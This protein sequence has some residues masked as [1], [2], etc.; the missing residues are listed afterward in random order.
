ME[1]LAIIPARG[2]S[3]SV[4][5]KN[6]KPMLGKPMVL[7]SVDACRESKHITRFVVSTED[8]E[9]KE[10]CQAYGA[11]VIDRPM[12]LAQDETKTAPVMV[13]AVEEL[14]KE[15]YKPD[16]VLLIQPT[17]PFRTGEFI[18]S[19][20]DYFLSNCSCDSCFSGV[21]RGKS[22]GMWKENHDGSFG[23]LY[24]YLDR[25]RRQD[26]DRHYNLVCENG[27]FYAIRYET[28]IIMEDFIGKNPCIYMNEI[29]FDVDEPHDFERAERLIAANIQQAAKDTES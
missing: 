18:D 10:I 21:E 7:Y 16:Y 25:P 1:I 13:H 22:H 5:R 27:A 29:N 26:E 14:E 23:A 28:F 11:E 12:E 9:I 4:K 24:D 17:S 8:E 2:G 3:K 15:G 6:I 19:A 20:F